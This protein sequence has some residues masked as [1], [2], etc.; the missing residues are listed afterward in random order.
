M[1]EIKSEYLHILKIIYQDLLLH[2]M[3][4]VVYVFT[5]FVSSFFSKIALPHRHFR[6]I[7]ICYEVYIY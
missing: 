5:I 4:R 6:K 3:M 7:L 1:S 2:L